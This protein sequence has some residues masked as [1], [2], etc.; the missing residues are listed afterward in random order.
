[1]LAARQAGLSCAGQQ[2]AVPAAELPSAPGCLH[3]PQVERLYQYM[4]DDCTN[5]QVRAAMCHTWVHGGTP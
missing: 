5:N 2:Q 3:L 4:G 1:M